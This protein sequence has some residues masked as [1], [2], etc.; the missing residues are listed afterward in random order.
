MQ[1]RSAVLS[2]ELFSVWGV[3]SEEDTEIDM[4]DPTFL[5]FPSLY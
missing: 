5:D 4:F 2:Q 1:V 3:D